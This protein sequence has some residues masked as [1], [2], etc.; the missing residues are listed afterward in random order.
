MIELPPIALVLVNTLAWLAL[1]LL[2]PWAYSRVA[3]ASFDPWRGWWRSQS[4]ER[5]GDFWDRLV[6]VRSWKRR[7]PDGAAL[8]DK[9]FRKQRLQSRDDP[10]YLLDFARET[11][12]AELTHWTVAASSLLFFV[13]NPAWV[14]ALMVAY[15]LLANLPFILIQ[16]TNRP[17]VLRL[18]ASGSES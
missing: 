18:A 3:L 1:H 17:F 11:C 15:G 14:G 2:I 7:A 12:R 10:V 6:R 4:W 8:F 16:R 5:G 13:W 9:G